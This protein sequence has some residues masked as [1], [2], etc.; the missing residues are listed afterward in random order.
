MQRVRE[1][2]S[3]LRAE[4]ESTFGQHPHVGDIRGRGLFLGL[5]IVA[6]RASKEPFD[7]SLTINKKIKRAAFEAGLACY[8]MGGTIDGKRGDHVLLAPP[9]IMQASQI[10]EVVG[11]LSTAIDA[12]ISA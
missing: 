5:E 2:G 3:S 9:F 10:D 1:M 7:P 4:L 12:A 6:D 8:P 11:K